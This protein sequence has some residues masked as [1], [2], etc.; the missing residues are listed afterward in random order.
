MAGKRGRKRKNGL[1]FGPDEEEAVVNYLNEKN[2]IARQLIYKEFLEKPFN[3]LVESM[4]R[5]KSYYSEGYSYE[6]LHSDALSQLITKMDKFDPEKGNKAYSYFGTIV[7]HYLLQLRMKDAKHKKT[8]QDFDSSID[9]LHQYDAYIY[10]LPDTDYT[11][12]NMLKQTVIDIENELNGKTNINKKK[13]T[14]VERK[15]GLGL[16]YVLGNWEE[17]F[18]NLDGENK[19]NKK[20]VLE[21]M[22]SYTGLETKEIRIGLKRFGKVYYLLKIKNIDEGYL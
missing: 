4:I 6:S 22:R 10:E 15:V 19:Y 2:S 16:I 3:I 11:M 8:N 13:I 5:T 21:T 18:G 12:A 20:R 14:E 17:V 1:Y 7:K 9:V